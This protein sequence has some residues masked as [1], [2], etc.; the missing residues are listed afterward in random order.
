MNHPSKDRSIKRLQGALDAI[1]ALKLKRKDSPQFEKWRRDTTVAIT[2]TFREKPHYVIHFR[3][4]RFTPSTVFAGMG[5][6]EYH[7]DYARGLDSATSLL[8][9]M[10]DEIREYWADDNPSIATSATEINKLEYT[11][12]VFVVHGRDDGAKEAVAR[13]LTKLKLKPVILHEQPNRGRTIIEKFEEFAQV[14][15]AI[16][17]LT[18]DD[19]CT[20]QDQSKP[21]R[22]RARQNVILE[23]GFFLG[24]LG[25]A[26]TFALRKDDVEIPSDY[27]G[28]IYTPM[29][30]KGAWR[31]DLVRELK[32]AGLDVDANLAL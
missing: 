20:S 16:V 7:A 4:I 14:G 19:T 11:N 1:S 3:N 25:R 6:A 8:E 18:P 21:P 27:D 12:E 23:L 13:L 32:A 30:D 10:I 31:M 9:S 28:V 22:P 29:D 15:F 2:N 24:K 26:Q 5:N 17:L